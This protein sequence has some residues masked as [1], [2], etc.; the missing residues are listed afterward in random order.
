MVGHFFYWV[1]CVLFVAGADITVGADIRV[2]IQILNSKLKATEV[3]SRSGCTNGEAPRRSLV[4][5]DLVRSTWSGLGLPR[6]CSIATRNSCPESPSWARQHL[7]RECAMQSCEMSKFFRSR[8]LPSLNSPIC[9]ENAP[10]MRN[11]FGGIFEQKSAL[12]L[13]SFI[14]FSKHTKFYLLRDSSDLKI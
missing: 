14:L 2:G 5:Q 3:A 13:S 7:P 9:P 10:N 1:K 6:V 12:V 11:W 4:T 8:I